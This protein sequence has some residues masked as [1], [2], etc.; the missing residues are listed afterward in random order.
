MTRFR[1]KP[2]IIEAVRSEADEV[3]ETLEGPLLARA[4]DWIVTGI[5]GERYPVKP[6]IFAA[7]YEEVRDDKP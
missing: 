5:A 6:D 1:K 2:I 7:T 3:I 4:G